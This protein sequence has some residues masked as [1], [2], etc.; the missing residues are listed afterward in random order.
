[1][2][3]EMT[4]IHTGKMET[5]LEQNMVTNALA[6]IFKPMGLD[7][8]PAKMLNGMNPYY[9]TVLG[10]I[11]LFDSEI[12]ENADNLYPPS[13]VNLIGCASYGVQNNTTGTLRGGFNQTESELNMADHYMK[14]VY[15]FTTSQAN[16]TIS[17]V[18]LTHKNAGYSS[19]GGKDS[20]FGSNYPLGMQVCDGHLQYVYTNYTGANTGDK[21]SGCTIGT[22]EL[23][24]LINMDEDA[25]CYFRIDN[26]TK[27]TI[28]K[29]RAYMK[30]VSVLENPYSTKPL[31]D[32]FELEEL[33]TELP[34]NYISYNFDPADNCL[35]IVN[36]A[37]SYLDANGTFYITKVDVSNWK[38]TQYAM[39]NTTSERITL[40]GM[41][42]SYVHRGYI[43]VRGYNNANH[44]FKMEIGN[45]ANV[46]QL[47]LVNFTSI[48]GSWILRQEK[49]R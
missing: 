44:L 49:N 36:S 8:S 38:V 5:V 16:G 34:T 46:E 28:V 9:Q 35:Y 37:S 7:K 48:T 47:R 18:C 12:E 27:I 33:K 39:T 3:I 26:S 22:T 1:M 32:S 14:Y 45:S 15:D 29:R 20:P 2:K 21:Y 41:R 10:G 24:F 11:L 40:G 31:I 6:N 4:D 23:I 13:W 25:V 42:T 43:V 19:Y 30:S 17:C